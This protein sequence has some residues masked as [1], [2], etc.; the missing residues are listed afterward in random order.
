MRIRLVYAF[1]A[2]I[3][4]FSVFSLLVS[5]ASTDKGQLV[6]ENYLAAVQNGDYQAAYTCLD[7]RSRQ[8]VSYSLFGQFSELMKSI[9]DV[10]AYRVSFKG[11]EEISNDLLGTMQQVSIF[12]VDFTVKEKL[13]YSFSFIPSS[14]YAL[15]WEDGE[16]LV[17]LGM[18]SQQIDEEIAR[19]DLD[20]DAEAGVDAESFIKS[21]GN[22]I[23]ARMKKH[24]IVSIGK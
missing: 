4:V 17:V 18:T 21:L 5:G 15:V 9:R 1:M 8:K 6:L 19:Y 12:T 3:I 2:A 11:Y 13:A 23:P 14:D 16:W 7:S 22:E 20:Q 24:G 10:T